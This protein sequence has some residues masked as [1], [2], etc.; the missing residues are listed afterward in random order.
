[1]P[2]L[3]SPPLLE[4]VTLFFSA[5]RDELKLLPRFGL[6]ES[7]FILDG[8]EGCRMESSLLKREDL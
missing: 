7:N 5:E 3:L 2:S 4:S 6:M 1:M 8:E